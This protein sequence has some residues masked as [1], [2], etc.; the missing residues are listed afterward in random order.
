MRVRAFYSTMAANQGC[1]TVATY[2]NIMDFEVNLKAVSPPSADFAVPTGPNFIKTPIL[3][4]STTTNAA[5][6]QTWSFQTAT[7]LVTSGPKGKASWANTGYYNVKL[8]QE[9]CGLSDSIIKSVKIEKPTATPV[10]EFIA[11]SNQVEVFYQGQLF[12]LSTNGAYKWDWKATS[13]SGT[14]VYTSTQQNPI[15]SFDE[16]GWWEICLT[17]ENDIGPSSKLCKSRYIEVVPPG[18]F[19]MGP[20]KI[21]SNQGGVLYDNGGK[22]GNYGN[23]RKTSID[24]LL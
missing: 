7:N 16:E 12:D 20:S 1:G 19:Y 10:A 14:I 15:F 5:Y 13:P 18:E 22:T 2:G 23:N 17:S 9:F 8:K 6:K 3:F 4:N 24:R 11:S 21:A